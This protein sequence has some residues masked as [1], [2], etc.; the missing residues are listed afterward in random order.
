MRKLPLSVRSVLAVLA[1]SAT[2]LGQAQITVKAN[3]EKIRTV[4]SQ[5]EK[6]SGYVFFFSNDLSDLDKSITFQTTNESLENVLEK[7]FKNTNIA[8]QVK[9]NQQ[10]VLSTQSKTTAKASQ[11]TKN[12]TGTVVD[13]KGEPI[14]GASIRVEGTQGGTIT[15]YDGNFS[16]ENI[17]DQGSFVVSYIGYA[18]FVVKVDKKDV[19]KVK[20]K[21]DV[22][23]LGEIV[24][25]AMGIE[26]KAES[27][28]YATQKMGGKEFTRTKDVNFVN[29]LQGKAAGLTI[30]PNSSGAGGG[31]SKIVLRGQTSILGNNQPLIVLDGIPLSNGM[32]S[33]TT[34]LDTEG[35]RDG[36]DVLSTI[37]PDDIA[38][39]S[40]LKGPNAAALYGSAANNGVIII[41]TKSGR[42]GKVRVDVSSNVT[43]ETPFVYPKV[44]TSFAP[45]IVGSTMELD[46]W[47][48]PV[49]Q[50]TDDE[51]A[52]FPYLTRNPRNNM[53]DFFSTGQTYNNSVSLS[54]GTAATSSYFSY[55]NTTQKGLIENNRF[56]RHN[57]LLKESFKLFDDRV[58]LD[59]SLNYVSS[60]TNNRP[61]IGKGFSSLVGLYRTPGAIDLR[62][63]DR[64][65]THTATAYDK[66]VTDGFGNSKLIGEQVQ[67]WGWNEIWINNPYFMT[68]AVSD[69]MKRERIMATANAKV[70]ITKDLSFQARAS[71]DK[72]NDK[73]LNTRIASIITG[74][75]VAEQTGRY[76]SGQNEHR[77]IYS[78]YLLTY[79]K[80]IK[81]ISVSA[82]AGTSWKRIHSRSTYISKG[83]DSTYMKPN[84][85]WPLPGMNGSDDPNYRGGNLEASDTGT[86]IDWETAIFATAQVGLW[87]KA[88][89]D[90]S[91]RN[92]WYKAFQQFAKGKGYKSYPY[93]SVGGNAL[94]KEIFPDAFENVN[95]LKIRGSYSVVGN[96]IP[97]AIYSVQT[98]NPL[99]GKIS[100][101]AP[102][103]DNPK[104]ETTKAT[105]FGLDGILVNNKID[106]D[107][108][109]YRSVMENQYLNYSIASSGQ[110]KPVNS[111]KV[112]NQGIEFSVGYNHRFARNWR[113]RSGLNMSYNENKILQTYRPADGSQV[114][115]QVGPS[116]LGIRARY[117]EG[118]SY[119]DLYV[120]S[121]KYDSDGKIALA[122]GKP[123]FDDDWKNSR[124]VGNTAAK[125]NYGWNNTISYKDFSLY[126]LLDGKIGGKVISLTQA[127]MDKYGLSERS[128]TARLSNN[129]MV[130]LPDGQEIKAQDYYE[131][132]GGS[133]VDCIYNATNLRIREISLGYTFLDVF[134]PGKNITVSAIA[135]NLGFIYKDAPVDPDI[136]VSAANGASG[137]ESF[138]LPTTQSFGVN[139]KLSF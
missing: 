105:E 11:K 137:I 7:L 110:S 136:S 1:L 125:F 28:T 83:N 65:R 84:V 9:P 30:T 138:A 19:Y 38:D 21:E 68:D 76:W 34:N 111:G 5:I 67:T 52:M 36:G 72:V 134:G 23:A 124:K 99:T 89:I 20:L 97:N 51:L 49:S 98:I 129:G 102:S 2:T 107:L 41:T 47:G 10:V 131:A 115:I 85:V 103:F 15:D 96:S 92:D 59:F 106:F 80:Q 133:Q 44:Q 69:E 120:R 3:S 48:K 74:V 58:K 81:D 123:L 77:E 93:W 94:L 57:L 46:G 101:R 82:T 53:S 16:L 86:N 64:N 95:S 40:I 116:S 33:Q 27:L 39:M 119:G 43:V 139:F 117:L 78:D 73:N 13:E 112:R 100:A 8:Y 114:E 56:T 132:I 42:E 135:R 60:K 35:G 18:P 118:G 31:S 88:Y 70:N 45:T 17:S 130:R 6:S 4:L 87:N 63:F 128:A 25:T 12:I 32:S 24:V 122:D 26:R 22:K 113:W 71:V 79:N 61:V 127:E 29:S 104:P 14:I 90:F 109:L 37:N 62:Y 75:T 66:V 121:Y 55:G 91:V 54:G 108:T 126:I 50:I